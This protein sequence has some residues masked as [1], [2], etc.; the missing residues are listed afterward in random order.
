L[1]CHPAKQ[2][3]LC[4]FRLTLCL[5]R[6][7]ALFCRFTSLIY[8]KYQVPEDQYSRNRMFPRRHS[9]HAQCARMWPYSIRPSGVRTLESRVRRSSTAVFFGFYYI[10][11]NGEDVRRLGTR[12]ALQYPPEARIVIP[13]RVLVA[14][15]PYSPPSLSCIRAKT[16][17]TLTQNDILARMGTSCQQ[18]LL[19][20]N[21]KRL[22]VSVTDG[23]A[24]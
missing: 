20:S 10:V 11:M 3:A 21:V 18:Q 4:G 19:E 1:N 13:R 14:R 12:F 7:D 17:P 15:Y 9:G 6:S 22:S 8:V 24:W 2:G 16:F 5:C 23:N